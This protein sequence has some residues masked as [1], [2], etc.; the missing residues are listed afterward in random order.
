MSLDAQ[1][2]PFP[3]TGTLAG[4]A[5]CV[6]DEDHL[7]GHALAKVFITATGRQPTGDVII[8]S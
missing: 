6:C 1:T 5:G 7:T 4:K 8:H 2:Y 3:S